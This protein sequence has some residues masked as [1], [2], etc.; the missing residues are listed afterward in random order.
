MSQLKFNY[1]TQFLAMAATFSLPRSL[2]AADFVV[3]SR[4]IM[5]S[6]HFLCNF[7]NFVIADF[8]RRRIPRSFR[9][10]AVLSSNRILSSSFFP[11]E[12]FD[13]VTTDD[14]MTE[15]TK[16]TE[17]CRRIKKPKKRE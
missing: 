6:A 8:R 15:E 3:R 9:S 14:P 2:D 10:R 16:R 5:L 17:R 11:R 13:R 4:Q 7:S 12:N 1:H